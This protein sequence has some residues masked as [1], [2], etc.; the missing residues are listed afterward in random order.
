MPNAALRG[1]WETTPLYG[2]LG[3]SA[4]DFTASE[5]ATIVELYSLV[6]LEKAQGLRQYGSTEAGAAAAFRQIKDAEPATRVLFYFN[7]AIDWA[8]MYAYRPPED[9]YLRGPNGALMTEAAGRSGWDVSRPDMRTWWVD[10]VTRQ[11]E[12][13]GYDG[14]FVDGI[15]HLMAESRR[16]EPARCDALQNGAMALL[17]ALRAQLGKN[18]LIIYNGLSVDPWM[19]EDGGKRF[20]AYADGAMLER[21][22]FRDDDP[23]ARLAAE[24]A[25]CRSVDRAGKFMTFKGWPRFNF[26]EQAA[27]RETPADLLAQAVQDI[28][29]PLA[30]F[31]VVS[32]DRSYFDY[33]WGYRSNQGP[34]ERFSALQRPLGKPEGD[35]TREGDRYRRSFAH[36]D[37]SLDLAAQTGHIEWR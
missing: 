35:A 16:L 14:V 20:L 30:A 6:T 11:V 3:K 29:F 7:A 4:G 2:H 22:D 15:S 13:V 23:P 21:F 9:L 28:D 37:V 8:E 18:K 5:I 24:L 27:M 19:G 32:G 31:L 34:L 25:L 10:T 26:T 36:A 17:A 12:T 33:S 1:H